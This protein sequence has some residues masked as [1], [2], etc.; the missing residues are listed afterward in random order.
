MTI[1]CGKSTSIQIIER[2]YDV[3]AGGVVIDGVDIRE[4]NIKHLRSQMTIVG[5]EPVLFNLS[6]AQ[7]IAY[8]LNDATEDQIIE[9]ARLAN[10]HEFIDSLPKVCLF[11]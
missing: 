5:Q 6:I 10:V 8:G 7:N 4:M 3:L 1:L 11:N 2:Y 9:A